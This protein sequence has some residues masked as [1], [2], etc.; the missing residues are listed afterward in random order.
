MFLNEVLLPWL[1]QGE[2]RSI[3]DAVK[4]ISGCLRDPLDPNSCSEVL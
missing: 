1:K 2:D 4:A 3:E